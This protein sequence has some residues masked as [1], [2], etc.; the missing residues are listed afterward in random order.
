MEIVTKGGVSSPNLSFVLINRPDG[1]GGLYTVSENNI[2]SV[3]YYKLPLHLQKLFYYLSYKINDFPIAEDVSKRIFSIP[4]HPY[5]NKSD[6]DKILR[7][8]NSV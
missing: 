6:Q 3:I 2:P 8:L 1:F 5:L 4:M 7:V